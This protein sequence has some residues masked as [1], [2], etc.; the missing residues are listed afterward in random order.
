MALE[1]DRSQIVSLALRLTES[2]SEKFEVGR[3]PP[4]RG[5]MWQ[6]GASPLEPREHCRQAPPGRHNIT[7]GPC[8]FASRPFR[9]DL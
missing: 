4:Q 5:A 3:S 9:A 8:L 1:S 2:I 6:P 7:A